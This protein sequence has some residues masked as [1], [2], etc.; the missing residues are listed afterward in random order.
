MSSKDEVARLREEIEL[1]KL[2]K[3]VE[4]EGER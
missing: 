3:R 2:R 1:D 4:Q